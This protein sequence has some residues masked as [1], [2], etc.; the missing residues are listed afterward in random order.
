L[1]AGYRFVLAGHPRNDFNQEYVITGV[2]HE[3]N[4]QGYHNIFTCLPANIA[5]RPSPNTP[6]PSIAGVLPGIVVGP[7]GEVK[8]VDQFGESV[9]AFPGG[10][11]HSV[12]AVSLEIAD[13]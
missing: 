5:F 4:G 9:C 2:E 12:T 8:H 3:S 7:Q 13:G 10:I 1:Q 6:Q 11:P